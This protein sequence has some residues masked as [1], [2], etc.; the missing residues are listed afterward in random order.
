MAM[1]GV[2]E[3]GLYAVFAKI[4]LAA[5]RVQAFG[6]QSGLALA[7]AADSAQPSRWIMGVNGSSDN[8]PSQI[9]ARLT[10]LIGAAKVEVANLIPRC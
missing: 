9:E 3:I 10:F 5:N 7:V 6:K 2:W 8:W 4:S 1:K